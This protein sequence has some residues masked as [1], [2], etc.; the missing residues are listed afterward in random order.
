MAG[1][2]SRVCPSARGVIG[3][4]AIVSKDCCAAVVREVKLA[5]DC[6][7]YIGA[8]RVASLSKLQMV[9]VFFT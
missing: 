8:C 1:V 3:Q 5:D 6:F 7:S 4:G 2:V 9:A